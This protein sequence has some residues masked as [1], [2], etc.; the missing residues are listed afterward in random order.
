MEETPH[1]GQELSA[2]DIM[3]GK[4][5]HFA[6]CKNKEE[7]ASPSRVYFVLQ[8]S[9]PLLD[10]M[11]LLARRRGFRVTVLPFPRVP[12]YRIAHCITNQ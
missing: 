4:V 3:A 9:G 10:I 1:K 12:S 8:L 5:I 6:M 11:L 2:R 7:Q